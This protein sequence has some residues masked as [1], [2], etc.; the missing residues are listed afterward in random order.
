MKRTP[1][2]RS[3]L[4]RKAMKKRRKAR[5]YAVS[6][7]A[8]AWSLEHESCAACWASA[9]TFGTILEVHHILGGTHGRPDA[10]WNFL[11]LC[12]GCHSILQGGLRNK[13]ICL[14]LKRES[15]VENYSR[16]SM[17]QHM[18]R[19]GTEQLVPTIRTLPRWVIER[20]EVRGR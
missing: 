15:D 3:P 4:R 10:Y 18:A 12:Q 20:R 14:H 5:R 17:Q 9:F 11:R 6:G 19:F 2:Q 7:L 13:S 8:Y 1:L 16:R